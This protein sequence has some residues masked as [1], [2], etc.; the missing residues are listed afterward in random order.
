MK[1]TDR[2]TGQKVNPSISFCDEQ[3]QLGLT[4]QKHNHFQ[5]FSD[6]VYDILIVAVL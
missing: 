4:N 3:N 6:L 1:Q 5:T 2:Q